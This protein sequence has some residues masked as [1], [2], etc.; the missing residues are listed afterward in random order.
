MLENVLIS[1]LLSFGLTLLLELGLAFLLG[2]RK[3]KDLLLVFLVNAAT[4]PPLVLFLNLFFLSVSP[5]WYLIL[6]LESCV[7]LAEWLLYRKRLE[8]VRIYPFLLSLL[9]NLVSYVGGL[10]VL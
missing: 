6:S 5:P 8:Y 1:V 4:N 3:S 10:I 9:L 7:V 2:I